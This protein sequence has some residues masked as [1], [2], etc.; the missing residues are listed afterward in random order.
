MI[1]NVLWLHQGPICPILR[2]NVLVGQN[3]SAPLC[4][5]ITHHHYVWISHITI[6]FLERGCMRATKGKN[7][8]HSTP[9]CT[10]H[11]NLHPVSVF[12]WRWLFLLHTIEGGCTLMTALLLHCPSLHWSPTCAALVNDAQCTAHSDAKQCTVKYNTLCDRTECTVKYVPHSV[13]PQCTVK[14]V[15]YSVMAHSAEWNMYHT[16]WWAPFFRLMLLGHTTPIHC[17]CWPQNIHKLKSFWL[18][19]PGS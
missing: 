5:N 9:H 6:P 10:V 12:S 4:L 14:Y 19:Q 16:L 8:T 15:P 13:L 11:W 2:S 18:L 7:E 17:S 3:I 1:S